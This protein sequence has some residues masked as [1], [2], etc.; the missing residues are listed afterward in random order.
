MKRFKNKTIFL[1]TAPL[2]YFIEAKAPYFS[3]ILPLFTA[4]DQGEFQFITSTL[5]LEEVLVMPFREPDLILQYERALSQAPYI[6]M[7]D[8]D[9]KV[10]KKA[11]ELRAT[12]QIKTP[13]ALQ[14]ATAIIYQADYFLS[15][16]RKLRK[17]E[18]IAVLTLDD[19]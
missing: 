14:L 19:L 3:K 8:I 16:D 2:I 18:E 17:V 7:Y 4:N 5:T 6:Q 10:A 15:N 9:G 12:H 13:D 11:A 1:D